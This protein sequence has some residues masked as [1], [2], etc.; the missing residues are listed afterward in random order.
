MRY[1]ILTARFFPGVALGATGLTAETQFPM[2]AVP[3]MSRRPRPL[4]VDRLLSGRPQRFRSRLANCQHLFDFAATSTF[5]L[6]IVGE[7][8]ADQ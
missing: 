5:T 7:T 8:P 2:S 3:R 1:A 6:P 4:S